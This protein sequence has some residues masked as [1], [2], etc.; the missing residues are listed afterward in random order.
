MWDNNKGYS[1]ISENRSNG[2]ERLDIY[3]TDG[4]PVKGDKHSSFHAERDSDGKTTMT[5]NNRET[6]EKS[7]ASCYLTSA[8]MRYHAE[9]F[10]D[11]CHELTVLRWF[12]DNFVSKEDK[13]H[14]YQTAPSI[15]SAID[16]EEKK[17]LVY[18]YVYDNVVDYCVKA[19]ENGDYA[20]AYAR[21]KSSILSLEE[22]FARK[23]L[24]E[25]FV[26]TLRTVTA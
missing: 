7:S 23:P 10:D 18:D 11:N 26:K 15:V 2:K 20:S 6:G 19:I 14:Y 5:F 22:V 9:D 16:A 25:S 12:R 3:N 13:E 21:Y 1:K 8:C 24:Q 4:H 17:D